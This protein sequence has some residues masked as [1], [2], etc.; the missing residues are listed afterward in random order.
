MAGFAA[1][2]YGLFGGGLST[3]TILVLMGAGAVLVFFG[4]GLFAAHLVVPLAH[5]LGAPAAQIGGAPGVLA[6][7]NT[8]RSPER[9]G[10][11]AAA[12]MIGL[13]LVT[14]V[15]MLAAGIRSTFFGAVDA[16]WKTDYAVTAENNFSPIPIAAGRRGED[17]PASRRSR[18]YVRATRASRR[19]ARATAVDPAPPRSST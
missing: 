11:S 12:L 13:A 6:R 2:A 18:T 10:S 16:L 3:S 5:A 15:A 14:L 1:L 4:V 7:E 19:A 9:T 17:V 8:Q